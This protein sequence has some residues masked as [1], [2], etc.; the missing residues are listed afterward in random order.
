[1]ATLPDGTD[2]SLQFDDGFE[3]VGVDFP[4]AFPTEGWEEPIFVMQ[5]FDLSLSE[6]EVVVTIPVTASGSAFAEDGT[7]LEGVSY[8]VEARDADTGELLQNP[9]GS[10][11]DQGDYS[12]TLT[13]RS[14]GEVEVQTVNDEI[15]RV[16][17]TRG[18]EDIGVDFPLEFGPEGWES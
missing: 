7:A 10:C 16:G 11:D 12:E 17:G 4:P 9:S 3:S 6:T 2:V 15:G 5:G 14:A 13:F 18:F 8:T 1:M